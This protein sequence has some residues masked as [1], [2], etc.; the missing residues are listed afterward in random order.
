MKKI[1]LILI[2]FSLSGCNTQE[3]ETSAVDITMNVPSQ[4]EC[5]VYIKTESSKAFKPFTGIELTQYSGYKTP[6]DLN[7]VFSGSNMYAVTLSAG[8]TVPIYFLL[9]C[10][11]AAKTPFITINTD[12]ENLPGAFELLETAKSLSAV[13]TPVIVNLFPL[14]PSFYGHSETYKEYWTTAAKIFG[15]YAPNAVLVCTLSTDDAPFESEYLPDSELIGYIGLS[16]YQYAGKA[17]LLYSA[18]NTLS[19]KRPDTPIIISALGISHYNTKN[20][21]Y[22]LV[23][24]CETLENIYSSLSLFPQVKGVIYSD[25]D[26]SFSAPRIV[27]SDDYRITTEETLFNKYIESASLYSSTENSGYY[28]L[29]IKGLISDGKAYVNG[30]ILELGIPLSYNSLER[31]QYNNDYILL[32]SFKFPQTSFDE[33]SIYITADIEADNF[34]PKS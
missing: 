14:N 28:K 1:L 34:T 29:P 31:F 19:R 4:T 6:L 32:D 27:P 5:D 23:E 7:R 22:S 16:H 13:N 18:I 10:M 30:D 8:R 33:N 21:T 12:F 2:I 26:L 11:T 9:Q 3:N 25:K 17:E 20:H 15:I 24:A